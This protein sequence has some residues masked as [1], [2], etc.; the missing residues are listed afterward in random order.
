M[1]T[2]TNL[3]AG[4]VAC[5]VEIIGTFGPFSMVKA[6]PSSAED[7]AE[8]FSVTF[9]NLSTINWYMVQAF[10]SGNNAKTSDVDVSASGNVLT[11]A[12]G[13]SYTDIL[14]TDYFMILVA[15]KARV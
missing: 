12:A 1:A 11:I 7:T 10:S 15:G 2:I 8:T 6:I 3:N 14:S 9:P 5:N 4:A 13:S